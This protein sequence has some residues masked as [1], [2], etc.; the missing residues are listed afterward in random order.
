MKACKT[1]G[2]PKPPSEFHR[3]RDSKDGYHS[4]CGECRNGYARQ[5]RG[6]GKDIY[7]NSGGP[8]R[9]LHDPWD[10]F[11]CNSSYKRSEVYEM[12]EDGYLAIGTRFRYGLTTWEV[13][14][15]NTLLEV[16]G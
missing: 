4:S 13:S 14:S 7:K 10:S 11:T 8:Y 9:V 3:K 5:W 16:S 6:N 15:R 12:L 1:C 2:K